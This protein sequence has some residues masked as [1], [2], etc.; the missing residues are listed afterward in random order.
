L[1]QSQENV[2]F[3]EKKKIVSEKKKVMF[4]TLFLSCYYFTNAELGNMLVLEKA[5]NM[6]TAISMLSLDSGF[7]NLPSYLYVLT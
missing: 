5:K 2:L 4:E 6:F 1:H 7:M 3:S